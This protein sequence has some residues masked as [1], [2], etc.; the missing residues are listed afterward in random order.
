MRRGDFYR[1]RR[2][3]GDPTRSR[4]FVV[5]S[6]PAVIRS[7]FPTVIC[8]P[9]HSARHG[10]ESEVP[11]GVDEGLKHD[12]SVQCD[13]LVSLPKSSLTDYVGALSAEKTRALDAAL[14]VAVGVA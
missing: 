6:R 11:V 14:R 5:V 4:V 8:A 1:I 7:S 13:A 2:P 12:S 10:I 9:V 3:G